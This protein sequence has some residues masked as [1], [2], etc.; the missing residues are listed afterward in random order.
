MPTRAAAMTKSVT[1]PAAPVTGSS[2]IVLFLTL[3]VFEE[4]WLV[5][6]TVTSKGAER[7]T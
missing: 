6:F 7:S 2:G 1:V 5:A 3:G 4:I